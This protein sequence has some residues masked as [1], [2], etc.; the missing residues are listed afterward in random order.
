MHASGGSKRAVNGDFLAQLL[1]LPDREV[2]DI[3][4]SAGEQDL[5]TL[6]ADGL[7][8][9]DPAVSLEKLRSLLYVLDSLDRL[10]CNT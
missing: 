6:H 3:L 7:L 4:D 9:E 10:F 8:E 1:Q 5:P 2:Q